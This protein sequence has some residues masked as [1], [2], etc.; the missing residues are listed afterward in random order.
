MAQQGAGLGGMGDVLPAGGIGVAQIGGGQPRF[1]VPAALASD[2]PPKRSDI[3]F[4]L[5]DKFNC[6][7]GN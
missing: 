3:C 4:E 2:G 5:W 6:E 7:P 1:D